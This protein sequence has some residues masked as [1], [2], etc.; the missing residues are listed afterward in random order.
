M[1][2]HL[3]RHI[4]SQP[5]PNLWLILVVGARGS[6][7]TGTSPRSTTR[8]GAPKGQPP[9]E[10]EL[11]EDAPPRA[12]LERVYEMLRM[13]CGPLQA[14]ARERGPDELKRVLGELAPLILQALQATG[15]D[16]TRSYDLCDSLLGLRFMPMSRPL[17]LRSQCALNSILNA[18]P[19]IAHA[20][21][22]HHDELVSS[23][24]TREGTR[25]LQRYLL[26]CFF[27]QATAAVRANL[28]GS[29]LVSPPAS[30]LIAAANG[31][32]LPLL[33]LLHH[34]RL[35]AKK[36]AARLNGFSIGS[37]DPIQGALGPAVCLPKLF[38][39][40]QPGF[41]SNG[42]SGNASPTPPRSYDDRAPQGRSRGPAAATLSAE[43]ASAVAASESAAL[44][45]E[46][47]AGRDE[48]VLAAPPVEGEGGVAG[49]NHG[50]LADACTTECEDVRA[51]GGG[52]AAGGGGASAVAAGFGVQSAVEG[53]GAVDCGGAHSE[54]HSED[55]HIEA[56]M[57]GLVVGIESPRAEGESKV[58]GAA[59]DA[60]GSPAHCAPA[61]DGY[62]LVVFRMQDVTAAILVEDGS[63]CWTSH[64]WY[65]QLGA[66]LAVELHPLASLLSME[67]KRTQLENDAFRFLYFNRI[68][69]ALK[70]S[71]R[72]SRGALSRTLNHAMLRAKAD[73]KAGQV[74]EAAYKTSDGWVIARVSG[75]R[76]LYMVSENKFA[77][78]S[79]LHQEVLALSTM[80]LSHIFLDG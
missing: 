16:D 46:S 69:L 76:E 78:L 77:T 79:E 8:A 65:Q 24:M 74:R 29:C 6:T 50:Q 58:S 64:G 15:E 19:C 57:G 40:D 21:L 26:L 55:G 35:R 10:E 59:E 31:E 60:A 33:F 1:H 9:M 17:Y 48:A 44:P 73:L 20:V 13:C 39:E 53:S 36:T 61:I 71:L 62:R 23:S 54:E 27:S 47:C 28:A 51:D 72:S 18:H 80:H 7:A 25:Q 32:A 56:Q 4:F 68:N 37:G 42:P 70:T 34:L 43:R 45:L 3:Q 11:F 2:T 67:A 41:A 63:S 38:F 66:Q 49:A 75:S 52:S 14:I 5:E 30:V 12:L 22:L